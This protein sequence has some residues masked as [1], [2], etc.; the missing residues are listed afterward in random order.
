MDLI[1]HADPYVLFQ[2]TT[3]NGL[4]RF[5]FKTAVI[6]NTA[7]PTWDEEFCLRNV[8]LGTTFSFQARAV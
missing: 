3:P 7:N 2:V 5:D 6:Y 8:P 1:G 4:Q